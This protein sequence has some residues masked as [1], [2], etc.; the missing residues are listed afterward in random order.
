MN[1]KQRY[2]PNLPYFPYLT[3][4]VKDKFTITEG[5]IYSREERKFHGNF[6]HRGIYYTSEYA[7]PVYAAASG[8]AIAGYHRMVI[9]N[10]DRSIRLI[11]GIPI[12]NGFGYF[13][14]IYHPEEISKIKGGRVTQ[15]A[16]LAGIA[17]GIVLKE[18]KARIFELAAKIA[19]YY[20]KKKVKSS[21]VESIIKKTEQI[22]K[23]YPWTQVGYGYN[24]NNN[25]EE[26]DMYFYNQDEIV[27]A[28]D[29]KS[30]YVKWVDQGDLIGYMGL[31]ALIYAEPSYPENKNGTYVEEFET[32]DDIHL[33]FEEASRNPE[34]RLKELQ[35]DPYGV[36]K[37][38]RHYQVNIFKETLFKDSKI[39]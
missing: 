11:N 19:E 8:Y 26:C 36:Y 5:F 31:S 35:R 29:A 21:K 7:T 13:V 4:P 3:L 9:T 17:D 23:K 20:R 18:T 12:G 14:Q 22:V 1:Y 38:V 37:S 27:A 10:E 6:F 32:W 39:D 30:P 24:L 28:F 34:T 2:S 33:H 15:Y 16:H 25:L